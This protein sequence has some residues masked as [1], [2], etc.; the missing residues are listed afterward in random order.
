MSIATRPPPPDHDWLVLGTGAMACLWTAS[1]LAAGRSVRMRARMPPAR[2]AYHELIVASQGGEHRFGALL[3][4]REACTPVARVLVCTKAGAVT[5]ALGALRPRIAGGAAVVL[6]QNGMGFQ[7]AAAA[8]LPQARVY[9]ALTTEGA[10]REAPFRVRHAG[11]GATL[12]G[13][14]PQGEARD[15][16]HEL[17]AGLLEVRP[18]GAIGTE[19]WRKLAVNCAINPL[20]ALHGCANGA[21]LEQPALRRE[22]E[23]LCGEIAAVLTALGHAAL[24]GEVPATAR[25]VARA[26]AANRSSMLQ[27]LAAGRSTEIDWIT[28]FL[29]AAARRQGV[30]CPLNETLLAAVHAREPR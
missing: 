23:A 5:E 22:F 3:E 30:P 21:L 12:I 4:A 16:A 29:C 19:A 13:R 26:T 14:W 18:S 9:A 15:I 6:M 1:L 7:D 28:G 8:L 11:R 2:E 25:R 10:W 17:G 20:T 24:A 27:D